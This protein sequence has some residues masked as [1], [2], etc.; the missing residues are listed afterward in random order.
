MTVKGITIWERYIERI[1][2]AIAVLTLVGFT[3]MQ[4]VGEPNAV[5]MDG[6]SVAPGEVDRLL[7]AQAERLR[8]R[9]ASGA[10]SAIDFDAA[11]FRGVRKY[12]QEHL[13]ASVS[14]A[15]RLAR[16]YPR[17][18]VGSAEAPP[19]GVAFVVP[20]IPA[21]RPVDAGQT[22]D[23]LTEEVVNQYAALSERF[24]TQP[25]DLTWV[26]PAA[27]FES[28]QVLREFRRQGPDGE[29]AA[30]PPSWY[31]DRVRVLDVTVE[32]Q[33]LT[34]G[35]WT[36]LTTLEPIPGQR[37]FRPI[38]DGEVDVTD[39]Q[40]ILRDLADPTVQTAIIQ[41]PFYAT[42]NDNWAAPKING[43]QVNENADAVDEDT[44]RLRRQLARALRQRDKTAKEL[45]K[46][47]GPLRDGDPGR[48]P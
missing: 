18:M 29:P 21:P 30:I 33:E 13:T 26:T 32:R 36:N 25:A 47:G 9:L 2:L 8:S 16:F 7:E 27:V 28:A 5:T 10:A 6:R 11:D 19:G 3:V 45:D 24:P 14:P 42:R 22:F 40:D 37:T 41:P 12:F 4:F 23:A 44:R 17:M 46:E 34:G 38:L 15:P 39:R 20:A 31:N 1:V 48:K 43:S 35:E